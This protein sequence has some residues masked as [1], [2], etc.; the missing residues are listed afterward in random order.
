MAL[1][2]D[3]GKAGRD[4]L[5]GFTY[6][7]KGSVTS[8]V[9]GHT[10]TGNVKADG[11]FDAKVVSYKVHG[12]SLEGTAANNGK[13]AMT[14]SKDD[15]MKGLKLSVNTQALPKVAGA[16][17][18]ATYTFVPPVGK[19]VAV[20]AEV[21]LTAAPKAD[22]SA[23]YVNGP[24]TVGGEFDYDDGKKTVGKYTFGAQYVSKEVHHLPIGPQL[25]LP[26]S[27]PVARSAA[28][29]KRPQSV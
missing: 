24:Y 15:L 11:S 29:I 7:H 6:E 1:F 8:K 28:A 2:G 14:L 19:S 26:I 5:G 23:A 12:T 10:V 9:N 21:G 18:T 27:A 13:V 3:I 16:K 25:P 4:L 17:A 22:L 20:K